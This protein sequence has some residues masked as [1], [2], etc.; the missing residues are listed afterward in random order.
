MCGILGV[1]QSTHSPLVSPSSTQF[2]EIAA[3]YPKF[4]IAVAIGVQNPML[5][6]NQ[7]HILYLYDVYC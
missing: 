6:W 1:F 7:A 5:N 4:A 2:K 3:A